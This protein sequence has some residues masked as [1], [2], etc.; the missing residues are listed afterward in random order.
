MQKDLSH[1]FGRFIGSEV[2][3]TETKNR[4][5]VGHKSF[6]LTE[7]RPTSPDDQVLAELRR[8]ADRFGLTL[9]IWW[10]GMVATMEI[11]PNRLNV[12]I[13]KAADGKWRIADN[14]SID[15]SQ[16]LRET[17]ASII[18]RGVDREVPV[19][20]PVSLKMPKPGP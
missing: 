15:A 11:N 18:N 4:V 16:K 17:F 19:M 3:M 12:H 5:K 9:R 2:P 10:P 6:E 14:I 20:K 13:E 1:I 7:C 8:E